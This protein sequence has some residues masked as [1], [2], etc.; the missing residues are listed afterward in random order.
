MPL[1][2]RSKNEV[3]ADWTEADVSELVDEVV[4]EWDEEEDYEEDYQE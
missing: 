2:R 3:E 1:R 4:A